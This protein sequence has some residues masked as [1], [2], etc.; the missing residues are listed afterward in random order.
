MA[1]ISELVGATGLSF[2]EGGLIPVI[3]SII[4]GAVGLAFAVFFLYWIIWRR[5]NW[6]LKV[7]FKIPRDI[8]SYVDAEGAT[9]VKGT[10]M[11]EWGKGYYNAKNGV[12]YVKRKGKKSVSMK[13]FDVKRF[14]SGGSNILTVV[15]VGIED[16]RPVIDDSYIQLEDMDTGEEAVLIKTRIDTSESK[17]WKNYEEREA[18]STYTIM[19]WLSQHGA[20]VGWGIVLFV[21]LVGQAIVIGKLR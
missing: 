5:K 2:G 17:S 15:Q 21:V 19:G 14:L 20:L 7:E 6:N 1:G 11:K 12:V 9:I 10:L 3:A 8:D 13:P 4:V 18:K 16:Y